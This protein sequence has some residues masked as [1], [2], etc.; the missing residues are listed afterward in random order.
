MDGLIMKTSNHPMFKK[1]VLRLLPK[2]KL[3]L[4]N[5][6]MVLQVD[7]CSNHFFFFFEFLERNIYLTPTSIPL[8]K[9]SLSE[10]GKISEIP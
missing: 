7:F 6:Q 3:F 8:L 5:I 1:S 2:I 10:C 9:P 4:D